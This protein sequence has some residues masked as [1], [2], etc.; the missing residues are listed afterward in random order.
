MFC[1]RLCELRMQFLKKER[2]TV[3]FYFRCDMRRP[4]TS[5]TSQDFSPVPSNECS[6]AP[7]GKKYMY[8]KKPDQIDGSKRFYSPAK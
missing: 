4:R 2:V 8:E 1:P 7:R 5:I 6:S 3:C